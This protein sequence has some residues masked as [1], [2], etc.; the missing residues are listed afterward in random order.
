[1][2]RLLVLPALLV[3]LAAC[4]ESPPSGSAS[5]DVSRAA[6]RS[7]NGIN[8]LALKMGVLRAD[9]ESGCLWLEGETGEP[10][11][12]LLLQ[13]DSYSVNFADS[14]PTVRDGDEVVAA[15]GEQVQVG[16]GYTDRVQVVPNC[17]A[18]GGRGFLGRFD[19]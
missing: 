4:G 19:S 16:G 7:S 9:A 10:T 14:P 1:M 17:P 18:G 13:G 12:Q 5:D 6:V 11:G 8:M 15:V 3:S 2:K